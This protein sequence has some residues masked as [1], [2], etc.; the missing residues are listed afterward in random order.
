MACRL[1]PTAKPVKYVTYE[2]AAELAFFGAEV[3]LLTR[4]IIKAYI[5][6]VLHPISMQP[7]IMSQIPVRVKNSYNTL[8]AGTLITST[9]YS[10]LLCPDDHVIR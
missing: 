2:E 6:Q 1:V 5:C 9:R 8:A 7:A 4:K 3:T 10:M